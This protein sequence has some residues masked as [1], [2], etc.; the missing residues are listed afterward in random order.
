MLQ[1]QIALTKIDFY[2][3]E[4]NKRWKENSESGKDNRIEFNKKEMND[5]NKVK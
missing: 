1:K 5:Q 4:W 3:T 2:N